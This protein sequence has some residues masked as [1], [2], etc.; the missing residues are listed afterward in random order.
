MIS[1]FFKSKNRRN[2]ELQSIVKQ[3]AKE[4]T[5]IH[6]NIQDPENWQ[7]TGNLKEAIKEIAQREVDKS[8]EFLSDLQG[9][10][11]FGTGK[12]NVEVPSRFLDA[13]AAEHEIITKLNTN[14]FF[15][16]IR[17]MTL[18]TEKVNSGSTL[19]KNAIDLDKKFAIRSNKART[20]NLMSFDNLVKSADNLKN[21]LDNGGH[22]ISYDLETLGGTN[23]YGHHDL[24]FITEV[25]A[26]AHNI[27]GGKASI[28]EEMNTIL[29]MSADEA[30]KLREYVGKIDVNNMSNKDFVL[31]HRLNIY[32]NSKT[33]Y[34]RVG[35]S[36]EH[37]ITGAVDG[38]TLKINR[39]D[40]FKAI[41][42]FEE[43]GRAQTD[44]V[45]KNHTGMN[46]EQYRKQYV[47]QVADLISKGKGANGSYDNFIS[48]GYNTVIF[49]NPMMSR[50]LGKQVDINYGRHYD[51]FQA[52]LYISEYKG[53]NAVMPDNL[54][55]N[56]SRKYGMLQQE[57]LARVTGHFVESDKAA[58]IASED[59]KT[60]ARTLYEPFFKNEAGTP[61]DSFFGGHT[62]KQLKD[63]EK[64]VS[65]TVKT[66]LG[67]NK[68]VYLM[69]N[70]IQKDYASKQ[71]ALS[72]VYDPIAK[73]FKTFDG[74]E[75][76][77]QDVAKASY[78]QYGPKANAL[79]TH[80]MMEVEMNDE[81]RNMI[82]EVANANDMDADKLFEE[83][84]SVD[85]LYMVKS[86]SFYG[87]DALKKRLGKHAVLGTD[88]EYFSLYTNKE[89]AVQS[90]GTAV[91]EQTEGN[92]SKIYT[93]A[94][95]ALHMSS[96]EEAGGKMIKKNLNSL[97]P[98]DKLNLLMDRSIDRTLNDSASRLW[99]EMSYTKMKKLRK[100]QKSAGGNVD[101]KVAQLLSKN[102]PLTISLQEQLGFL[103]RQ[104]NKQKLY[105][106]TVRNNINISPYVESMGDL[107]DTVM[108]EIDKSITGEGR[109]V[110]AKKQIA[111]EHTMNNILE[112]IS[113][114]DEKIAGNL[115]DTTFMGDELNVIDFDTSM[116]FPEKYAHT[117]GTGSPYTTLNLNKNDGLLNMFYNEKY[118]GYKTTSKAGD[119][120][121]SSLV[122]A[123][124]AISADP[125]FEGAFSLSRNELY[126][127]QEGH[128]GAL[129]D[130]LMDDLRTFTGKKRM[131][132]SA[133]GLLHSRKTQNVLNPNTDIAKIFKSNKS[134]FTSEIKNLVKEVPDHINVLGTV[135]ESSINSL[136]NG[137]LLPFSKD[138]FGKQLTGLPSFQTKVLNKQYD[139]ALQEA[140]ATA[141]DLLFAVKKSDSQLVMRQ[142]KNGS[143]VLQLL[144]GNDM[145]D[146]KLHKYTA[147]NGVMGYSL[148]GVDYVNRLALDS[149]KVVTRDKPSYS[150]GS[151]GLQSS[152]QKATGKISYSNQAE[153]AIK[154]GDD[155]FDSIIR[156]VSYKNKLLREETARIGVY[157]GQAHMQSMMLDV[158]DIA[159]MLPELSKAG[160]LKKA[161]DKMVG[162]N[163][164]KKALESMNALVSK[165]AKNPHKNRIESLNDMLSTDRNHLMMDYMGSILNVLSDDSNDPL[166]KE[167]L[168]ATSV[169]TKNTQLNKGLFSLGSYYLHPLA[170]FDQETR[171]P[172][173]QMANTRLYSKSAMKQAI[174]NSE[175]QIVK[176]LGVDSLISSDLSNKYLY[177][178]IS[179]TDK[180]SA[181]L[182]MKYLQVESSTLRKV[183]EKDVLKARAGES[184][185]FM[186]HAA[187]ALGLEKGEATAAG[188]KLAE[189]AM[190]L[191]TY[192]QQAIMDARVHDIGFHKTNSKLIE[193][194]KALVITH[195]ENM[196]TIE[197][198][199]K[200]PKLQL[201]IN[202]NGVV[203]YDLGIKVNAGDF[204]AAV[205]TAKGEA[206]QDI[207]AKNKGVF[208]LR[209]FDKFD[210]RISKDTLND[211]V[212]KSGLKNHN[213]IMKLL[214]SQFNLKYEMLSQAE[215]H[216]HKIFVGPSEKATV[217]S[218]KIATGSI[219]KNI[220][221]VFKSLE[222]G[223]E[224]GVVHTK[225]YLDEYIKPIL[226]MTGNE[227]TYERILK[228]RYLFSDA[229]HKFDGLQDTHLI[230]NL[231]VVKHKSAS[232]GLEN[233]LHRILDK[234]EGTFLEE[235]LNR[236][237]G[238]GNF[239]LLNG[240]NIELTNTEDMNRLIDLGGLN[241]VLNK[242]GINK[243]DYVESDKKVI[244]HAGK[245]TVYH[246]YDEA[247]GTFA[248]SLSPEDIQSNIVRLKHEYNGLNKK[249]DKTRSEHT[250]MEL[251]DKIDINKSAREG[252]EQ[253]LEAT[254]RYKGLKY[255]DRMNMN[256]NR[257]VYGKDYLMNMKERLGADSVEFKNAT[258]HI[259]D[260]NGNIKEEFLGKSVLSPLTS[261][262]NEKL[263]TGDG[264]LAIKDIANMSADAQH[265]YGYLEDI[266]GQDSKYSIRR[267][268]KMFAYGQG[269]RAMQFNEN[270]NG[271]MLNKLTNLDGHYKFKEID[272]NEMQLDLG[273]QG[274]TITR[275]GYNPYTNS[276]VIN[277]GLTEKGYDQLAIGR[278]PEIHFGDSI[279][280]ESHVQKLGALQNQ[281]KAMNENGITLEEKDKRTALAKKT[282]DDIK[283]LQKKDMTSKTGLFGELTEFRMNESFMGKASGLSITDV[284]KALTGE[285]RYSALKDSNALW[286]DQ[287]K[288]G[289]KSLLQH[290]SEG[291]VF[292]AMAMSEKAFDDLGYFEEDFMKKTLHKDSSFVQ[293]YAADNNISVKKALTNR[294]EMMMNVLETHGDSF[295]GTRFPEIQ[296]GSD[297]VVMGY[298]NRDLRDNQS[299]VLAHTGASAKLDHDGDIFFASRIRTKD[300]SSML[301]YNLDKANASDE[302]KSL[303]NAQDFYMTERSVGENLFFDRQVKKKLDKEMKIAINGNGLQSIAEENIIDNKIFTGLVNTQDLNVDKLEKMKAEFTDIRQQAKK[304]FDVKKDMFDS[305]LSDIA[306]SLH[307]EAAGLI[308]DKYGS[309]SGEALKR[310]ATA[311][312]Y[313]NLKAVTTAKVYN[314]AIGETNMTMYKVKSAAI[315][316]LDKSAD[317]YQ[318]RSN[319]MYDFFY[320][321]EEGA[322]SS[323]S[324]IEGLTADRAKQWNSAVMDVI[325]GDKSR[326]KDM[327]TWLEKNVVDDLKLGH[328]YDTLPS[329]RTRISNNFKDFNIASTEQFEETLEKNDAFKKDVQDML[330]GDIINTVE[331]ISD[332]DGVTELIKTMSGGNSS[333]GIGS[334]RALS[335]TVTTHATTN[336]RVMIDAL[337]ETVL[338]G[339]MKINR[340]IDDSVRAG[341]SSMDEILSSAEDSISTKGIA[342]SA[343]EGV[344]Q[345]FK[346][347]LGN[348]LAK[349]AVGIAAAVM[350][351]GFV[352]GRPRPA[353]TQALET[354]DEAPT[355]IPALY[356]QGMPIQS[357]SQ[358]GYVVNI[359]AKT[360]KG[361]DHAVSAIQ[362]AL[363]SGSN[364]NINISMNINEDHGNIDNR[365]MD[366]LIAGALR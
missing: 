188:R 16:D 136:V 234:S 128:A 122:K 50:Y 228:E 348:S 325:N 75:I 19:I 322:I 44:W 72:F 290:Y 66:H 261:S 99:R 15:S 301:N 364:S 238:K 161:Q 118:S 184:N 137:Y 296:E 194:K 168:G 329:F 102:E 297:K 195:K 51:A 230:A 191:S 158:N 74:Y 5:D 174:G 274:S 281:I 172:V 347:G 211:I 11:V 155:A 143:S 140:Q 64:E 342:Q 111:Y 157:N 29:G 82:N 352:G 58:H 142:G 307:E 260:S 252:F 334:L 170:S 181:G 53:R 315:N 101:L 32:G 26:T 226:D 103:N 292:D 73:N 217:D 18:N 197:T 314:A 326:S 344:G 299:L 239:N 236:I 218:M 109:S 214:N 86:K 176:T 298:L 362:Q 346:A 80:H 154:N 34:E 21:I 151:V 171:P 289:E 41:D 249:L 163:F 81:F 237:F 165:I 14:N 213:D 317:D 294:R 57:Q 285:A 330:K 227:D 7:G 67:P 258:A 94:I 357:R 277:T 116:L 36:F 337:E 30:T 244:G 361:R 308:K 254:S 235:D 126:K 333:T 229:V 10:S 76:G 71:G 282:I 37:R 221:E 98:E 339:E 125:R 255:S 91:A 78:G 231:D 259:L 9:T 100:F 164:D 187:E 303:A 208:R 124:D 250:R 316:M 113:G 45:G 43:I 62:Y 139:L 349:G 356:D 276:M 248:G 6:G 55:N 79:Y 263:L 196:K 233:D 242:Y 366:Q 46:L 327:G 266:F 56:F 69:N 93:D 354:A 87:K 311:V 3:K 288:V 246:A 8:H 336:S 90:M 257:V 2:M 148:D 167:I 134:K 253:Q 245:A 358:S 241:E 169:R 42:M 180:L 144:R 210:Q 319:L 265:R 189:K 269:T 256:L 127:Y 271:D 313:D 209:Y 147:K 350:V 20:K 70:T 295:I 203:E 4:I 207:F 13:S 355:N 360:D 108:G 92:I 166:I 25:S 135:E 138:E 121:F 225:D 131:D 117:T 323:K 59:E 200:L 243:S 115:T 284:D 343:M 48:T 183:F 17:D 132:D 77:A 363:T 198:V 150:G 192:E 173:V 123:Y 223:D 119:A 89:M 286:L 240:S 52:N 320:H 264:D 310:Y 141:K 61:K 105:A 133:Y 190:S 185:I 85:K 63:I 201:K 27:N 182:S 262:L 306:P 338:K 112:Q 291:R 49:D 193:A 24:D 95:G 283:T 23:K 179:E 359:N 129:N 287:A 251:L 206:G 1:K 279:V 215:P 186:N 353:G 65:P 318:Y 270:P 84:S 68:Q 88:Y 331:N 178:V 205:E 345:A 149:S 104:T 204:L 106:D 22:I 47:G 97:S 365:R 332:S 272:I 224:L 152:V 83:Y 114:Y 300:G 304:T 107:I 278:T 216:G 162:T 40:A 341:R 312:S 12:G 160:V 130:I 222:L 305:N 321:A 268:E 328:Y 280:K 39:G 247:G 175:S 145:H 159:Y 120:G 309:E 110:A 146:L 219:D 302:L 33:A 232:L 351:A 35:D 38:K 293:K 31:M 220:Q 324:S 60:L 275:S 340:V 96:L 267:S 54:S 28:S 335:P 273:G 199:K 202:K 156:T 212:G 153:T 177:N